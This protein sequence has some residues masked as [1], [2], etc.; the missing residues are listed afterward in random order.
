VRFGRV[1]RDV[2]GGRRTRVAFRTLWVA[3]R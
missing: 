2:F 3:M 1:P